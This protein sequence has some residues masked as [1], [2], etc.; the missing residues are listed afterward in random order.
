MCRAT[1]WKCTSQYQS[2]MAE[3]RT[4]LRVILISWIEFSM[5][6]ENEVVLGPDDVV[7][8]PDSKMAEL[9][10]TPAIINE[11]P[12]MVSY[13]DVLGY[14]A[15]DFARN[16]FVGVDGTNLQMIELMG[17]NENG[18]ALMAAQVCLFLVKNRIKPKVRDLDLVGGL[19]T[20]TARRLGVGDFHTVNRR[21]T[22]IN[23]GV[24]TVA[25]VVPHAIRAQWLVAPP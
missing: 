3:L 22:L 1:E 14:A 11:Y 2:C 18:E 17:N 25:G 6:E 8:P 20:E 15:C 9:G 5:D 23:E 16:Y 19:A 7:H 4:K 12:E 21:R 10:V 13:T 24:L